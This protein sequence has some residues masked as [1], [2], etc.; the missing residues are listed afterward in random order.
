MKTIILKNA[1]YLTT[2]GQKKGDILIEGEKIKGIGHYSANDF[3]DPQLIDATPFLTM[4]GGIDPHVHMA[5]PVGK[6]GFSADDFKHGSMAALAGGTTTII[7]FVTPEPK[8]NL[9]SAYEKRLAEANDC[10]CDFGLHMS[11][12]WWDDTIP[13]QMA[14]CIQ[15]G[16]TSFKVYMAYQDT[17]GIKDHQ[18]LMTLDAAAKTGGLILVHCEDG[19]LIPYLKNKLIQEGKYQPI[20]HAKSRPNQIESS[21]ASR[22]ML[23]AKHTGAAVYLV[24]VSAKETVYEIKKAREQ[25]QNIFAETCPHYLV[26]TEEQYLL[27]DFQGAK[28]IMSPP[29]RTESDKDLLWQSLSLN[30]FDTLATDHCPFHFSQKEL[31]RENFTKI[32]NGIAGVE[33][34]IEL[35]YTEGLLKNKITKEQ[36]VSLA[37][38]RAAS[39]FGLTPNKGIIAP[40]AD[41]DLVLLNQEDEKTIQAQSHHSQCDSNVY[42]G[43]KVKGQAEIT[44]LRGKVAYQRNK[45]GNFQTQGKYLNRQV[46]QG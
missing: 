38:S 31:G 41:A 29:L 40:G 28:Y 16:M 44:I 34:R 2:T 19:E 22:I 39:I 3:K 46:S 37:S 1:S 7:D 24:H 27:P 10:C 30:Q 13:E 33:N 15:K 4:P 45:A 5:L 32:P 35:L 9:I 6:P 12:T 43:L 25:Q 17:V 14:Q 8:E 23:Y 11:I 26:F 42:E 36:F 21:A 18:L 20:Y